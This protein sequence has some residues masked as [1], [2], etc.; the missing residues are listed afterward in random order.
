M[1]GQPD[2]LLLTVPEAAALL[3]IGRTLMYE[4]IG[5]GAIQSVTV[6]RLR[7]LRRT[8]LERYAAGLPTAGIDSLPVAA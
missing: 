4:L 3:G 8:D 2:K 5:S 1:S 6:G 7:R